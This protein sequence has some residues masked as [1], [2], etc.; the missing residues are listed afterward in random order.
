MIKGEH[1][2][3]YSSQQI[4][5]EIEDLLIKKRKKISNSLQDNQ[6][7]GVDARVSYTNNLLQQFFQEKPEALLKK[8]NE[9]AGET[10][11]AILKK[12]IERNNKEKEKGKEDARL[13]HEVI[14]EA[15]DLI[16]HLLLALVASDIKWHSVLDE[17][18]ARRHP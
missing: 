4:I 18:K 16:F 3:E 12:S 17:L 13:R 11:M 7:S 2:R 8:I 15:A 9:E 1:Q 14:H 5:F 6:K 10:V